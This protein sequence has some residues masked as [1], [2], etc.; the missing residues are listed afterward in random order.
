MSYFSIY[1]FSSADI[2]GHHRLSLARHMH[3]SIPMCVASVT[4]ICSFFRETGTTIWCPLKTNSHCRKEAGIVTILSGQVSE[5]FWV[6][7]QGTSVSPFG[8]W[9]ASWTFVGATASAGG[10]EGQHAGAWGPWQKFLVVSGRGHVFLLRGWCRSLQPQIHSTWTSPSVT[11]CILHW[12]ISVADLI[13]KGILFQQ[14][15]PNVVLKVVKNEDSSSKVTC[16]NPFLASSLM[17]TLA[18]CSR[19]ATSAIVGRG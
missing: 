17:I 8:T 2:H 12:N 3:A 13:P 11:S 7:P 14:Y 4:S 19:V 18:L 15:L 1:C 10:A 5:P 6:Y 16:Q 9:S